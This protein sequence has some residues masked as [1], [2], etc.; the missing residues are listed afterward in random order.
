MMLCKLLTTRRNQK[1][2]AKS[3]LPNPSNGWITIRAGCLIFLIFPVYFSSICS[4]ANDASVISVTAPK[5]VKPNEKFQASVTIKNIGTTTWSTKDPNRYGLGSQEPQDN[6]IWNTNRWSFPAELSFR[7]GSE[8]V[9]TGTFAA[10]PTA[11]TYRFS[12]RMVQEFV[13]WFGAMASVQIQVGDLIT[14]PSESIGPNLGKLPPVPKDP[15]GLVGAM[16]IDTKAYIAD[17]TQRT[18][19]WPNHTGR[20]LKIKMVRLWTG[21]DKGGI[22]DSHVELYRTSDKTPLHRIQWDHYAE[23]TSPAQGSY[24]PPYDPYIT[25][26]PDDSLTMMYFTQPVGQGVR[27]FRAHHVADIWVQY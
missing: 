18:I 17:G 26:E 9:F 20:R 21:I 12:W 11:G 3:R 13:E 22:G 2:N 25:L 5:R 1:P 23:P 6:N 8:I 27:S 19:I 7:P 16:I 24:A 15:N 4:A 14:A 10:P